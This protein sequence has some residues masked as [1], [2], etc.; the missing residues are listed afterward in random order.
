ME[1]NKDLAEQAGVRS[2]HIAKLVG[3]SRY[4]ANSW[5]AKRHTPH[6]FLS[7]RVSRFMAAVK[8]ALDAGEL[9]VEDTTLLPEEASVRLLQ[10]LQARMDKQ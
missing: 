6:A 4:T 5:L 2:K 9:P 10:I 7:A 1:F 3:V 8:G